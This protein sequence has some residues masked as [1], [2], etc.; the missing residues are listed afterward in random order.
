MRTWL[1]RQIAGLAALRAHPDPD[2]LQYEDC[3][4][5]IRE[6]A[7]RAAAA[8]QL[9]FYKS[10]RRVRHVSPRDAVA[11]LSSLLATIQTARPDPGLETGPYSIEQAATRLGI[12]KSKAYQDARA[13]LLPH[14]RI[15]RR[16]VVSLDQLDAYR[17]AIEQEPPTIPTTFRHL[18]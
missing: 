1:K 7:D 4:S 15:G 16:I 10:H 13:G 18:S 3:A 11:I 2:E 6:A 14:K 5:V 17:A 8:G 9:G 12:S